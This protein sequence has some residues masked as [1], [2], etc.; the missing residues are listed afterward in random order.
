MRPVFRSVNGPLMSS[1]RACE[2]TRATRDGL[3]FHNMEDL[4]LSVGS[5]RPKAVVVKTASPLQRDETDGAPILRR[6]RD[7]Q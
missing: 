6:P 2:S 4:V 3:D 5:L 7:S 1:L